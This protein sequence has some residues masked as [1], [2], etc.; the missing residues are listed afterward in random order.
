[1][2]K[3]EQNFKHFVCNHGIKLTSLQIE[4]ARKLFSLP[5]AEGKSTLIALL[6]GHDLIAQKYYRRIINK[7]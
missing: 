5:V 6:Y 7:K 1:M 3:E 4:V 2:D